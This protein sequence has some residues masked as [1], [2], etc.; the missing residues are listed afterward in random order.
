M[1]TACAPSY[2][3]IFMARFEEK[4]I[5]PLTKDRVER[6]LRYTDDIFFIWK[7]M[8]KE[9]ETF[10]NKINKKHSSIKFNPKYSMSDFEFIDVL[11]Y[12]DE[13]RR[14]QTTLY[15]EKKNRQSYL[16]GTSDQLAS[17]KTVYR[18]V[19]SVEFLNK[20]RIRAQSQSIQE[21]FTNRGCGSSSIVTNNRKIKLLDR[22][23]LLTL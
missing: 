14:L 7:E 22:K 4:H 9:M 1:G 18:T 17:L 23:K 16:H 10:F 6:Y 8:E 2:A 13:K 5:Y 21:Q 20:Q 15:K 19:N 12:K 3:N 11:V